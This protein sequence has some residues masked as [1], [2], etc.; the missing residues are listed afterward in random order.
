[1]IDP[2]CTFVMTSVDGGGG[3]PVVLPLLTKP[4][5]PVIAPSG[6]SDANNRKTL[7]KN[8]E[9]EDAGFVRCTS[10][11]FNDLADALTIF[12]PALAF[13]PRRLA[14]GKVQGLGR[15]QLFHPAHSGS[16]RRKY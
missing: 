16:R 7:P 10:R 15:W 8:E 9:Q 6:A 14:C 3:L 12:A 2:V 4:V 11:R 1:V 13:L 5:Q